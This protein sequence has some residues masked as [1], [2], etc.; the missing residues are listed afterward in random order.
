MTVAQISA[1]SVE[2]LNFNYSVK[3]DRKLPWLPHTVFDDGKH[4]YLQLPLA[5][6]SSDL[7]ALLVE[8]E[9]GGMGISNYRVRNSSYIVDGLFQRAELV[10]GVGRKRKGSRS[11]TADSSPEDLEP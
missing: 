10:V 7:P 6:R 2:R 5:A 3:G 1:V 4:V 11:S 9:G 8:V